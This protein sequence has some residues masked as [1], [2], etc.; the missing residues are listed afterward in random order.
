MEYNLYQAEDFAVDKRFIDWVVEPTVQEDTFWRE[1][2]AAHPEKAETVA[3]A[4]Q[5]IQAIRLQATLPTLQEREAMWEQ[6]SVRRQINSP[7]QRIIF[8]WRRWA[9]IVAA[10][11]L[12]GLAGFWWLS[13]N[14]RDLVVT[15][16]KTV[17]VKETNQTIL[18]ANQT[19]KPVLIT[20]S[21]GSS[22]ILQPDSKLSYPK[23]FEDSVRSISLQGEAFFEVTKQPKKP[24]IVHCNNVVTKVLG[25]SFNIKAYDKDNNVVVTVRSGRVAV[26]KQAET[27]SSETH[28]SSTEETVLNSNEQAT[29]SRQEVKLLGTKNLKVEQVR[30]SNGTKTLTL[31][32]RPAKFVYASAPVGAVF[33]ELERAYGIS[34][35]FDEKTVGN[36]RLTADLN[37]TPLAQKLDI[38][39]KSVEADFNIRNEKIV[40]S[41]PGCQP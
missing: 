1:W 29:I 36:C 40:V 2:L 12:I 19:G 31:T 41:G 4:R 3:N 20:L 24:F 38:I 18:K 10:A 14:R 28:T 37:D 25:T 6:I 9:S 17:I 33:E 22:V 8:P 34:I 7:F 11:C 23:L 35:V 16:D 30:S 5:L 21:D 26:F 13:V 15:A 32:G 27:N 39:C